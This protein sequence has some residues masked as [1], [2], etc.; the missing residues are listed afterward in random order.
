MLTNWFQ[1][2]AATSNGKSAS[3]DLIYQEV[4]RRI[5][6]IIS[7]NVIGNAT[8]LVKLHRSIPV[9]TTFDD[10]EFTF[11]F[12]LGPSGMDLIVTCLET[13]FSEGEAAGPNFV[14]K[15]A[16]NYCDIYQNLRELPTALLSLVKRFRER[17]FRGL[18]D[19][20]NGYSQLIHVL[21]QQGQNL[22]VSIIHFW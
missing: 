7:V 3:P 12:S 6:D 21:D 10:D 15:F 4:F 20:K 17:T 1:R 22:P 2:L 8:D 5:M 19:P 9:W 11:I 18:W 13:V 14:R 16:S